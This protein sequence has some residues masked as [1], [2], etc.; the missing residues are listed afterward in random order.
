MS[1]IKSI[2]LCEEYVRIRAQF[3][4]S[5]RGF[6]YILDGIVY[7]V[8]KGCAHEIVKALVTSPKAIQWNRFLCSHMLLNVV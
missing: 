7:V 5:L 8:V 3:I 2:V 6:V 4:I 1:R